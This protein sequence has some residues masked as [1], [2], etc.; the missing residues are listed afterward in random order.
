M[1]EIYKITD[2]MDYVDGIE[3]IV[4]DLDDT[5]Y[6]EKEYVKS[7]YHAVAEKL[8]QVIDAEKKLW[9]AFEDKKSTID[10]ILTTEEIYTDELK[11]L[12]LETYRHHI[13]NIHLYQGVL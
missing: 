7:G 3:A 10:E 8:S 11:H 1:V 4:F 13:P 5:L 12:C 6:G 2:L 9:K